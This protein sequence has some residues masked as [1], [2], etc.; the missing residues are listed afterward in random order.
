MYVLIR[1]KFKSFSKI[2]RINLFSRSEGLHTKSSKKFEL[3]FLD[4]IP[5]FADAALWEPSHTLTPKPRLVDLSLSH[6]IPHEPAYP[7]LVVVSRTH[8]SFLISHVP[9]SN[10]PKLVRQVVFSNAGLVRSVFRRSEGLLV[11][12]YASESYKRYSW[13]LNAQVSRSISNS[14]LEDVSGL[15]VIGPLALGTESGW[16]NMVVFDFEKVGKSALYLTNGKPMRETIDLDGPAQRDLSHQI[17]HKSRLAALKLTELRIQNLDEDFENF[18]FLVDNEFLLEILSISGKLLFVSLNQLLSFEFSLNKKN[19]VI[20]KTSVF[21]IEESDSVAF[22]SILPGSDPNPR[23]LVFLRSQ[24]ILICQLVESKIQLT[25]TIPKQGNHVF[26][27]SS[28]SQSIYLCFFRDKPICRFDF[29]FNPKSQI[30]ATF[31]NI[32]TIKALQKNGK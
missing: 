22:C 4:Q 14:A 10:P 31:E 18:S 19:W 17:D 29:D 13:G 26:G 11:Q 32:C 9:G 25:R 3:E 2:F 24:K 21:D 15:R 7:Q 12:S 16:A 1:P 20:Q 23:F 27:H 5:M 6:N 28:T 8:N 30:I